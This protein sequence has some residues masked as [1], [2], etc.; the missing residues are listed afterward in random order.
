[1]IL[2]ARL[3]F[4]P[5][6]R[7][8][9]PTLE[10]S[11][12]QRLVEAGELAGLRVTERRDGLDGPGLR[13]FAEE[14]GP[15]YVVSDTFTMSWTPYRGQ[16]HMDHSY[17]LTGSGGRYTV[18]DPYHNDTQW[19]PAR[20][21]VWK[22]SGADLDAAVGTGASAM[23]ISA[24]GLPDV[25]APSILAA[26][27]RDLATSAGYVDLV[28]SGLD[29]V[30]AVEALV[31]DIWL[32]GR[33][34][35][36]HAAW[37]DTV[38]GIPSDEVRVQADEWLRLA[39]QS[40]LGLRRAVRGEPVPPSILDRFEELLSV[41]AEVAG[42][43][44]VRAA[45]VDAVRAVMRVDDVSGAFRAMPDFSSFRLVDIIERVESRLDVTLGAE[46]LT[47]DSLH[48]TDSLTHLFV[49]AARRVHR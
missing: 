17:L 39:S 22:L 3:G 28:R 12:D 24:D 33:S 2:G 32:L 45:V 36:L 29:K 8:D 42:R 15:L 21:G 5:R 30:P 4:T 6:V 20:P 18:V 37:L 13:R 43:L 34:R 46:D 9:L 25:N 44:A 1:M 31:L 38:P 19:G 23:V 11:V 49:T 48:D 35:L 27:A 26:N 14:A 47:L 16:R 40:Y 7:A 41:D 10:E